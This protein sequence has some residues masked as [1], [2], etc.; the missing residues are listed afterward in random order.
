MLRLADTKSGTVR[1]ATLLH[2]VARVLERRSR[3]VLS[4]EE[5]LPHAREAA[6]VSL[7]E[8]D[9]DVAFLR[10]GLAEVR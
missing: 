5:D 3:D 8:L 4:L 2:H 9:K 1:G 7:A 6:K 10:T